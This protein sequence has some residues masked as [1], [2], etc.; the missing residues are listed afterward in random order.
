[1]D[2]SPLLRLPPELREE[3]YAYVFGDNS[4]TDDIPIAFVKH[5][6]PSPVRHPESPQKAIS[7]VSDIR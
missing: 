4:P 6:Y 5:Y 2:R 1:M 3:I 7:H